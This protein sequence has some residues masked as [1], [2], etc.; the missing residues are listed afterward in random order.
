MKKIELT[1]REC[2]YIL[3][4]LQDI[5]DFCKAKRTGNILQNRIRKIRLTIYKSIKKHNHESNKSLL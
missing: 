2:N 5:S 4:Q 3:S 1:E